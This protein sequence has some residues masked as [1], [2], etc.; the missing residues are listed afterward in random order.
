M[1]PSVRL[2][3]RFRTDGAICKFCC[4]FWRISR[5]NIV[6]PSLGQCPI[7]LDQVSSQAHAAGRCCLSPLP[8]ACL[9]VEQLM[10]VSLL[11][12]ADVVDAL[13]SHVC[14]LGACNGRWIPDTHAPTRNKERA[15]RGFDPR[16]LDSESRVLTVTPR[17]HSMCFAERNSAQQIC[18]FGLLGAS[19]A[20]ACNA[21]SSSDFASE[22]ELHKRPRADLNR[23]RWIQSPEC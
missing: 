7:R 5:A 16:S 15:S 11:G 17:G 1:F 22:Q 8:V 20:V 23:D 13:G 2:R 21:T 14:T 19:C 9:G 10:R 4:S 6:H 3:A 12:I 18:S